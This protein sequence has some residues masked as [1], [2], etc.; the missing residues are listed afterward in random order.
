MSVITDWTDDKARRFGR[1]ELALRHD[2][3]TRSMFDDAGLERVLDL[4]PRDRLGVFTMG[5]DPVDWRSWRRGAAQ[6]LTGSQLL[7]AAHAG[8]IWLNLRRV[9]EAIPDYAALLTEIFAD[10]E[11]HAPGLATFRRDMGLLISSANAQVFYHLDVPLVT[12]WGLR[13]EKTLYVYPPKA[14]FV[15]PQE[16]EAIVLKD[17][18]EQF[19]F[20]P[21]WD[22]HAQVFAMQP[23][24]MITWR[25]NAPHRVVNGP[26]LNVSLSI[27][28]MTRAALLRANVIYANGVLRRRTG[29]APA[30][31]EGTGPATLAK[32]GLA[33]AAK[34][35]RRTPERTAP[36]PAFRLDGARPGDLLPF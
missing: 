13:G 36:P 8:R 12:L 18:P 17:K 15:E 22:A 26:M 25:Q 3:H 31:Q 35:L 19:A 16:L 34:A 9:D 32:F 30:I 11:G 5:E 29:R 33:R 6:G 7:E 24:D 1:D 28:F 20:E 4:Y 27:E 23:G 2:L 10:L 21:A 14:P